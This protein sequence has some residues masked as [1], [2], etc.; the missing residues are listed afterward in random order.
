MFSRFARYLV[1][2]HCKI[3]WKRWRISC[4]RYRVCSVKL[5]GKSPVR[6]LKNW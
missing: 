6:T 4:W 2:E 3:P 1:R 5:S